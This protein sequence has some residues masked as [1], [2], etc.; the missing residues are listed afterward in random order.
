LSTL[1]R[2]SRQIH[3]PGPHALHL[4]TLTHTLLHELRITS[5]LG[6]LCQ[7]PTLLTS[8]TLAWKFLLSTAPYDEGSWYWDA[9]SHLAATWALILEGLGKMEWDPLARGVVR[10]LKGQG[11]EMAGM[12][13]RGRLVWAERQATVEEDE[14]MD[15]E[16]EV[17]DWETYEEELSNWAGVVRP[18]SSESLTF[19]LETISSRVQEFSRFEDLNNNHCTSFGWCGL[20][21][22]LYILHDQIHW[23]L[24]MTGFFLADQPPT[25]PYATRHYIATSDLATTIASQ[26]LAFFDSVQDESNDKWSPQVVE[27]LYWWFERWGYTYL[28]APDHD[29]EPIGVPGGGEW[30]G[31]ASWGINRMKKDVQGWAAEKEVISQVLL[32]MILLI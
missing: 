30:K 24:L 22:V 23:T 10:D 32:H 1:S 28:F 9:A 7:T 4:A 21:V 18:I 12:Y 27:T 13:V 5:G 20:I 15:V 8:I 14:E 29:G 2:A 26:V 17:K 16:I 31:L 3:E 19:I 6:L 11:A 25:L